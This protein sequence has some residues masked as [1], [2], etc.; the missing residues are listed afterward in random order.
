MRR[1]ISL[2]AILSL[3]ACAVGPDYKRPPVTV[4]QNWGNADQ[5]FVQVAPDR[6]K[7]IA[8]SWWRQ[9]Q[10]DTLNTLVDKTLA[11][12]NDLK[13]AGARVT[14]AQQNASAAWAILW[15]EINTTGSYGK[16]KVSQTF[17]EGRDTT[18]QA[19]LSGDWDLDVAGG[20]KRRREAALA[21]VDAA[22]AVENNTRLALIT[23]VAQNYVQLR[24]GQEQRALTQKN[25]E[26]QRHTL[27]ITQGQRQAGAISDFEVARAA[28]QVNQ[29]AARLPQIDRTIVAAQNHLCI[30]AGLPPGSFDALLNAPQAVPL[31]P[32]EIVAGAPLNTIARRPDIRAAERQLAQ[33]AALSNAAFADFFPKITLEGFVGVQ[34]SHLFGSESP[35]SAAVNG[36]MPLLN[37]GR[38]QAQVNAAD[39]RQQQALYNYQQA[40]LLALEDTENALNTYI[41]ELKRRDMLADAAQEQAK[42]AVIA[43]EQ[44]KAGVATQLDLLYAEQNQ[45]NADSDLAQSKG[46]AA[47]DL[48]LLYRALG[49]DGSDKPV[50]D[51]LSV[52]NS[53]KPV[54]SA[55]APTPVVPQPAKA[56]VVPV[57]N[58]NPMIIE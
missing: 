34:H 39:A 27:E 23:E 44:Y 14:E 35:W 46:A 4:T 49:D 43:R 22:R 15:P 1:T 30:L 9:F 2:C 41:N 6:N 26:M 45:L 56:A 24:S 47:I 51:S 32:T 21:G 25:L 18:A 19:G 36:I 11:N 55:P 33:A 20:N 28:A 8:G 31:L 37:W 16:Q 12:N 17:F 13:T 42:A 40:V 38:I 52:V 10:D 57:S 53:V 58:G 3:T 5:K 50:M 54:A 29:T 7:L 48:M